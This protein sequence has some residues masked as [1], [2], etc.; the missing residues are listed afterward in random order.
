MNEIKSIIFMKSV[1][2]MESR[3][4]P[5][6]SLQFR[7]VN[8]QGLVRKRRGA[9]F[10]ILYLFMFIKLKRVIDLH[11][12]IVTI[13][14]VY[15]PEKN[16]FTKFEN[17][18]SSLLYKIEFICTYFGYFGVISKLLCCDIC[19]VKKNFIDIFYTESLFGHW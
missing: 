14:N 11:Q 5:N 16:I 4:I 9:I 7:V 2:K 12:E 17:H 13:N 19:S 18:L 15:M 1:F 10:G 3:L 6:Y 8:E